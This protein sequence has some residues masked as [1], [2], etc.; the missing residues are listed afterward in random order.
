MHGHKQVL[1]QLCEKLGISKKGTSLVWIYLL[2]QRNNWLIDAF[3]YAMQKV[4]NI[5]L[6]LAGGP[7]H[8]LKGRHYQQF[9]ET[10]KKVANPHITITGF[11]PEHEIPLYFQAAGLVIL[12]Y[13]A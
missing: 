7:A 11:L 10:T 9:L 4:P 2:I 8:S 1:F 13:R 12:P 5:H 3:S 6:I